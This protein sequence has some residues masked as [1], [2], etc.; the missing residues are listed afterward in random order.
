MAGGA[1][2]VLMAV[3]IAPTVARAD[4][5]PPSTVPPPP[6]PGA[7]SPAPKPRP[8]LFHVAAP[9]RRHG[10]TIARIVAP[11]YARRFVG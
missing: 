10:A 11:T 6:A 9:S 7:S 2:G 1:V 3:L 5:T 4:K 8:K